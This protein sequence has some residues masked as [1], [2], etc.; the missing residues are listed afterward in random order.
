MLYPVMRLIPNQQVYTMRLG[1]RFQEA[2]EVM[3]TRDF[4]Q[5]PIT[6]DQGRYLGVLSEHSIVQRLH[7][8]NH[9]KRVLNDVIDRWYKEL[10]PITEDT[11]VFRL[12]ERLKSADAVVVVDATRRPIGV[13]THYDAAQFYGTYAYAFM[14]IEHIER[15]LR[16]YIEAVYPGEAER[17]A[18]L[19]T[20]SP[21]EGEQGRGGEGRRTRHDDDFTLSDYRNAILSRH[22]WKAF[23]PYFGEQKSFA[24]VMREIPQIRNDAMHFR[25]ETLLPDQVRQLDEAAT[26]LSHCERQFPPK[27]MSKESEDIRE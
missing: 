27:T 15:T 18:L 20:A 25:R 7:G 1:T 22:G 14:L 2:L 4:S 13:V 10:E 12:I 23:E 3:S 17:I 6:D 16:R 24:S 19:V 8:A 21:H 5:I 9:D 26:F 11:D